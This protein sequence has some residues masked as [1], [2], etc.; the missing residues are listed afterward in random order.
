MFTL[1]DMPQYK[2][3]FSMLNNVEQKKNS[4]FYC[5]FL[6]ASFNSML[7]IQKMSS[8]HKCIVRIDLHYGS[9]FTGA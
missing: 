8:L 3:T 7:P 6:V 1:Y 5:V 9:S 4:A 2:L